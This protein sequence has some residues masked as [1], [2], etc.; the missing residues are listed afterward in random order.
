MSKHVY[1]FRGAPA[2]GKGTIVPGFCEALPKPVALIEQDKFRWGIHTFG[3]EI[4]DISDEEHALAYR[5]T[6]AAYEEYL[7]KGMHTV[8]IEGLFTYDD[9][10]S[11]QGNVHE[12]R[13]LAE[14]HG[15]TFT[16]IVLRAAKEELMA[17][18]SNRD[19]AVPD[20]E[21]EVLCTGVYDKIGADEI[22]IDSTQTAVKDTLNS[23]LRNTIQV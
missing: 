1:V 8:V 21:F 22:V 19:Y 20:D 11:S 6:V 18:N 14:S 23:V 9:V 12:L 2:S 15:Y 16:S 4:A 5:V 10:A 7:R 17:R 3:R 13:S